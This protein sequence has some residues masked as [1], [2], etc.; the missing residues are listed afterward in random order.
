MIKF[1]SKELPD[2][3]FYLGNLRN[4]WPKCEAPRDNLPWEMAFTTV[5]VTAPKSTVV[6][7]GP[8][9][10]ADLSSKQNYL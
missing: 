5:C 3:S 9:H 2:I 7:N 10:T 6:E 1:P 4:V 8:F